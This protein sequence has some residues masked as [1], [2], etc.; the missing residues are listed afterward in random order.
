[1][2]TTYKRIPGSRHYADYSSDKLNECLT[3]IR[4]GIMS[5]RKAELHFNIPHRTIINK[6]KDHHP[7]KPGRQQSSVKR[8][9]QFFH[10]VFLI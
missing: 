6:L 2:L 1:M 8:R 3:D 4:N 10:V 7:N 5:R 9:N